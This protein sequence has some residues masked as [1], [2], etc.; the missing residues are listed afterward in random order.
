MLSVSEATDCWSCT[1]FE[2]GLL[3]GL[4]THNILWMMDHDDMAPVEYIIS[5][6]SLSIHLK[7]SFL[8][9]V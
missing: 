6:L 1:L 5:P 7:I 3:Q 8:K 9:A 2:A 4:D